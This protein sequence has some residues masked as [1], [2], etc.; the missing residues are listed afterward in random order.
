MSVTH[1][2]MMQQYLRIKSEY[3][4]MLLFYRM[5][6]F[7]EL[8]Y[9][10][11]KRAAQLLDLTLT[12][13]GQSADKP[14]P[15][16]GVPYHA[17]ENYLARLLKKGESV[18]IC[19]QIGDPATSKGPVERQVTRI[20]TPGTVTDE[21]LLDARK[22]N[23]LLAIF[24]QAKQ[25]GLAWVDLSGGRFHLLQ[26]NEDAPL[27]AEINRLQ[28]A[29]ILLPNSL[30]LT[31][32][33]DQYTIKIRPDWEFEY[34]RSSQ[35]LREQFAVSS[36][37]GLGEKD[38]GVA[39]LAAG[40]LLT[41]LHTTQRQSLPHLT[42]LTLEQ[43]A[44]YLQLDAS[45]QKHLELFENYQGGRENSLLAVLDHTACAMGSRL[46]KRWLGRPLSQHHLIE[47]RQLSVAELIEK[48][49]DTR[50]YSLLRQV[51]DV[52]R[53]V[54]RI[55][56]KSAR[57]RDLVQLRETLA[58]LPE[59]NE[60][61]CENHACLT[62]QL[63]SKLIPLPVLNDLLTSALVDNPPMLIRDGG[64]IAP[65]FDEELD[66]LRA[67]N[68]N[69]TDKLIELE[70]A[71]K[72]H[73]GL[74]SLKFGYNRV[75]GY[76]IELS[77]TQAEKAPVHYQRKQT[78]KNV[79]RYITPELKIFEEKVLS[80]QVKAL[81][82]EKWL[83]ES[84]LEEVLQFINPLTELAHALAEIDVLANFAERAQCLNWCQPQLVS[85]PGIHIKAGRHPVVEQVL[86]EQFVA[87]NLDLDR[88]QNIVL[89]TGP[90]MGGK[91]T[92]M[93]QNALIVLLAHIGSY[94]P[95]TQAQIGPIDKIFTRIGASDDLASGRSTFM[96]EMTET[97]H[98]LRQATNKSL[99]LID[100]IGRGTST[101][102]GMA[103]A[104]ATCAYLANTIN[105]YTLFSTHYFEL[106]NLPNHFSCIRNIHVQATLASGRIVFLYRV[107]EGAADRSYGLEVAQL[108]GIPKKVLEIASEH[109]NLVQQ[110][111]KQE[112][113]APVIK[114]HSP[115]LTE[116]AKIDVDSLS[117]R[118]ALDV[119]YR[120]KSL[121]A[122]H[123]DN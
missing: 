22:D 88:T 41:Y 76:Y 97:A 93:R 92:Y 81:A 56:L 117:P 85:T 70:N 54:S 19:E 31:I 36:L 65:G 1:T 37:A 46:L 105:A 119:L 94:V 8:F 109:L 113:P 114:L 112:L 28:P 48:K 100:E 51:C 107:E 15:M 64:V 13:R 25:Y 55:A 47:Q 103:L 98:I 71:E 32:L 99:V 21:A 60:I 78:L 68:D 121:E 89:M 52:E 53:I 123:A 58:R 118:E 43:N 44:D 35:L 122:F 57:P 9:D 120:L 104:Y 102:D 10:D 61:L 82:R 73:C 40:C 6:D 111:E 45:T 4:D 12:H 30:S 84:L 79:E 33:R 75:Q 34:Q 95:A 29:E 67:L 115:L 91:S 69:A 26:V 110:T 101:Y 72:Q 14:I 7:Y 77:R 24:Q 90:N 49:Q 23:I 2:P 38:Y 62:K 42:Q 11:A 50:L 17:V 59:L 66:E 20:I 86:Q 3:P 5:G 27:I 63:A 39:L 108:A 83:Y 80:A 16:A 116:L 87:N 74:S 96:V 106:T 18:A